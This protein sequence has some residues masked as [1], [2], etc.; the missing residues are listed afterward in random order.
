[1]MKRYAGRVGMAAA[2]LLVAAGCNPFSDATAS[3][4]MTV[5][6][7]GPGSVFVRRAGEEVEITGRFSLADGDVVRTAAVGARILLHSGRAASVATVTRVRVTGGGSLEVLG[8]SVLADSPGHMTLSVGDVTATTN[9]G[10]FRVDLFSATAGVAAY[11]GDAVV[12]SPGQEQVRVRPLFDATVTAG[13]ILSPKPCVV[14]VDDPWDRLHLTEVVELDE[15]LERYA[16]AISGQLGGGRLRG[17]YFLSL[18]GRSA[19]RA[20]DGYLESPA[21]SPADLLIGFSIADLD[22]RPR[23]R[24]LSEAFQ[25]RQEGG[26]WGVIATVMGVR[27]GPLVAGLEDLIFAAGA[28]ASAPGG[29]A[30]LSTG[31]GTAGKGRSLG[32]GGAAGGGSGRDGNGPGDNGAGAGSDDSSGGSGDPGGINGG[33]GSIPPE[34]EDCA[35]LID[36]VV[37]ILSGDGGL[38][39]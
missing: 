21:Y 5:E 7:D 1:M 20:M 37:G 24:A 17:S 9:R 18:K 31:S 29:P 35:N 28:L 38:L 22:S 8:G 26:Q 33:G 3:R 30:S 6:P 36:C 15:Q 32:D 10:V 4:S 14:D 27:A 25:L 19:G 12:A 13:E 34:E 16:D 39:P 11:T 23:A 2:T